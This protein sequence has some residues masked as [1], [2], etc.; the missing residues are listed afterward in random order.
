M[1]KHTRPYHKVRLL[2]NKI[3]IKHSFLFCIWNLD[4]SE[5]TNGAHWIIITFLT[6]YSCPAL[7]L[8][9]ADSL[10]IRHTDVICIHSSRQPPAFRV[11]PEERNRYLLEVMIQPT[12]FCLS[13]WS[14]IASCLHLRKSLLCT[15][16][17]ILNLWQ[18]VTNFHW[19][20]MWHISN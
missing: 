15:T 20:S 6:A 9:R 3:V 12:Y 13:A 2:R 16:T 5:L 17:I 4:Y 19:A 11:I 10:L 8:H 14:S 7:Y 18:I 1:W